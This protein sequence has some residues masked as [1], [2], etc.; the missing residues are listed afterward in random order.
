MLGNVVL[1]IW[2]GRTSES[3]ELDLVHIDSYILFKWPMFLEV[4]KRP[5]KRKI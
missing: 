4:P 1:L 3:R 5:T 2:H